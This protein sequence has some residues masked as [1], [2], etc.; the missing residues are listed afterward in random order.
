MSETKVLTPEELA[1]RAETSDEDA[2]TAIRVATLLSRRLQEDPERQSWLND[3]LAGEPSEDLAT[4]ATRALPKDEAVQFAVAAIRACA[5]DPTL[6]PIVEAAIQEQ[7]KAKNL[8]GTG[9]LELGI[10]VSL[11]LLI[12]K[13]EIRKNPETGKWTVIIHPVD[14][15]TLIELAKLGTQALKL[16]S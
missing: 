10:A 6:R 13:T 15:A 7:A 12:A 4:I 8:I 3:Q 16:F 5:A 2:F 9:V 14:N 1:N 11:V